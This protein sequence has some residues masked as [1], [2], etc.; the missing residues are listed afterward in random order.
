MFYCSPFYRRKSS[1]RD[2]PPTG[3]LPPPTE[4]LEEGLRTNIDGLTQT[5]VDKHCR[6]SSADHSL[7]VTESAVVEAVLTVDGSVYRQCPLSS[8]SQ[9]AV[10]TSSDSWAVCPTA[11]SVLNNGLLL[12]F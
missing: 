10:T 11:T 4:V 12:H 2:N 7:P 9:Q 1:E 5:S 8:F 3:V 6:W